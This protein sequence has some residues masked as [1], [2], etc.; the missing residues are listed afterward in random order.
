MIYPVHT[1][2]PNGVVG[3]F[4]GVDDGDS[5]LPEADAASLRPVLVTLGLGD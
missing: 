4:L 1:E 3:Q 2:S 5:E